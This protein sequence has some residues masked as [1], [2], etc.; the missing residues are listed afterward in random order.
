MSGPLSLTERFSNTKKYCVNC[1]EDLSSS[2]PLR[3][4]RCKVVHY[5]S[6]E[7]QKSNFALHKSCCKKIDKLRHQLDLLPG[8]KVDGAVDEDERK[9]CQYN[10][11]YTILCLG[12]QSTD[13]I[14]RGKYIYECALLEYYKLLRQDPFWIGACESV[15]LLL[16]ILGYDYL[17]RA[18]INFMLHPPPSSRKGVI[19]VDLEIDIRAH[20]ES[21][22]G[23]DYD[24]WIFGDPRRPPTIEFAEYDK[25][26]DIIP[27]HWGANNFLI[28]LMLGKMR[29]QNFGDSIVPYS[30]EVVEICRQVEYSADF[31]L[32]VLRSL[33]P[34]SQHR[35]GKDE[36]CALLANV[37]YR[38]LD[39]KGDDSD[40]DEDDFKP[41]ESNS[42]ENS[43]STFWMMLKDCYAFT[44][45]MLDTLDE[46][47]DKM[48]ELGINVI[49]EDPPDAPTSEEFSDF[50]NY[51][52]DRQ[53]RQQN[54]TL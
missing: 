22:S 15:V 26:R 7:C 23:E 3:C 42:W 28:P 13:T 36:V 39:S 29:D 46:T 16:A 38:E 24:V 6:R 12:Y 34:D 1:R 41:Y 52:A 9:A 4:S 18:L 27:K 33:F 31:V 40:E 35:W 30:L 2:S 19:G 49:A 43:C 53:E 51:M 32:P 5:C 11:A 45:G 20:V 50:I 14:D 17:C 37:D 21:A 48:L 44:P 10:L 25:I 54:R 8:E 47:I